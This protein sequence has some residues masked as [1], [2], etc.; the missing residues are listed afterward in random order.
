MLLKLGEKVHLIHHRRFERDVRRH[1]VGVV[2][3]YEL[4]LAR[5]NGYAFVTDDLNKHEF[6]RRPDRRT[7]IAAL[8]AG[9]FLINVIPPEVEIEKIRYELRDRR[10]VVTDG[11]WEMDIKEFGGG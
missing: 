5:L 11:S 6:V 3:D 9:N 4:G 1:F 8:S 7:K 2:E 10:L